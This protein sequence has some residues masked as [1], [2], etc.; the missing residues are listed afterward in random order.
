MLTCWKTVQQSAYGVNARDIRYNRQCRST[1]VGCMICQITLLHGSLSMPSSQTKLNAAKNR[2]NPVRNE[3][4]KIE[5]RINDLSK[6][7]KRGQHLMSTWIM[8]PAP[9]S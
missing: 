5:E 3:Q 6:K 7:K 2:T 4:K 8:F 9:N 1:H